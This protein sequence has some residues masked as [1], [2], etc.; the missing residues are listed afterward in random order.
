MKKI[1]ST[2]SYKTHDEDGNYEEVVHIFE[3]ETEDEA[4]EFSIL[5][6]VEQL[7]ACGFKEEKTPSKGTVHRYMVD[8]GDALVVVRESIASW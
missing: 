4:D 3:Y 7:A 8:A 2:D 6:H 1:F 5:S